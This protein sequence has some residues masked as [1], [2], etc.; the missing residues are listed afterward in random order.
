MSA[1]KVRR[2]IVIIGLL[3]AWSLLSCNVHTTQAKDP[4]YP[5]RPIEFNINMS[6]GGSTDLACRAFVQALGKQLGQRI[7]PVNKPGG[8]STIGPM[9][10]R[11]AKSDGYTLGNI[12]A[13]AALVVPFSEEAPFR[14]LSGFTWIANI[15]TYVY[16]LMV[17]GDAPWKTW[18][19]FVEWARKN[20][21]ATKFGITG[22]KTVDIKGLVM[23]QIEQQEKMEVTYIAFKGGAEILA[24]I[25]GG[26]INLYGSTVDTST[27]QYV[28]EGKLRILAYS[29]SNKVQGYENVPSTREMY[30][31]EIPN[32]IAI[33]GPKGLPDYVV[34]KLEDAS[35]KA[36]KD[37]DFIKMM[38]QM[39][40]PL[41]YMD[42]A[43][44]MKHVEES[45]AKTGR[46]YQAIKAEEEKGKK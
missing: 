12:N 27:M 30:G 31:F 37:P 11:N 6:V 29:G 22:A 34:K 23:W 26:H 24:A 43:A 17:R 10:V 36:M 19:E 46:I 9:A 1:K 41:L 7:I 28:E 18:K 32:L 15:G 38:A 4:D 14:D 25:L 2:H 21:R 13:S 33:V 44:L 20:P 40:M 16:P 5:V 3:G 39:N 8:S 45:F 35:A 42:R